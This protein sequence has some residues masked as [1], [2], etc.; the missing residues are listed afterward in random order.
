MAKEGNSPLASYLRRITIAGCLAMVYIT[1]VSSP[2]AT[3]FYRELGATD[4]HFGLLNGV[5]MIMLG[6]QFFGA[7]LANHLRRRKGWF[8]GLAIASRLLW[9]PIALLPCLFDQEFHPRLVAPL[10]VLTAL[11]GAMANLMTPLWFSWMGD[12]V[13]KRILNRYWGGRQWAMRLV[14]TATF[15]LIA[16]ACYLMR[17]QPARVLFPLF[18]VIGVIAGVIDILLFTSIEEPENVILSERP[19]LEVFLEPLRDESYRSMVIYNSYRA[20][21]T[22]IGATFMQVYVLEVLNIAVW[23]ANLIWCTVGLGDALVSRLWGRIL[24]RYGHRPVIIVCTAFKPA[25]CLVFLF[26]TPHYAAAILTISF[27]FDAMLNSGQMLAMNGYMLKTSPRENRSM[28]VASV[29][30]ITGIAGGIGAIAAGKIMGWA[31][32]HS[33]VFWGREWTNYHLVFAI[34]FLLRMANLPMARMIREPQSQHS[35]VVV[36]HLLGVWPLSILLYPVGLYRRWRYPDP[37]PDEEEGA[38][39]SSGGS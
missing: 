20:F 11:S 34:S 2:T 17:E 15:L 24:D 3:E 29:T 38:G 6:M 19:P 23:E 37:D 22:M 31:E 14:W 13:P 4:E 32:G 5:P 25:I 16:G 12:L 9:L 36:N 39:T 8:M 35:L 21:N 30:A 27:F 33:C 18:T 1:A 26:I 28:F 7:Y 10:I